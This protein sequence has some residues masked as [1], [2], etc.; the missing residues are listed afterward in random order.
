M[1]VLCKFPE[2]DMKKIDICCSLS[3]LYVKVYTLIPVH[4]LVLPTKLFLK[5]QEYE[6]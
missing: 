3:E 1:L 6:Y 2:D 5:M 4:L